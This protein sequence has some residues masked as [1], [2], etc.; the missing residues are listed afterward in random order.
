MKQSFYVWLD[1]WIFGSWQPNG[2]WLAMVRM[3]FASYFLFYAGNRLDWM[4]HFPHAFFDPPPSLAMLFPDFP[5]EW[6]FQVLNVLQVI[7]L[8]GILFG[9]YTR[10]NSVVFG[11]VMLVATSFMHSFGKINHISLAVFFPF[12][13]AWAGW[14]AEW[15]LDRFWR[16]K[17]AILSPVALTFLA[18]LAGFMFFT[19]G[20]V[21]ASTGWLDLGTQAVHSKIFSCYYVLGRTDL[22]ADFFLNLHIPWLWEIADW[23]VVIFEIAFLPAIFFP[24]IFRICLSVAVGFHLLVLLAMNIDFSIHFCVY[25]VFVDV[26]FL[27]KWTGKWGKAVGDWFSR[28]YARFHP[29]FLVFIAG[30]LLWVLFAHGSLFRWAIGGEEIEKHYAAGLVLWGMGF[31]Y[32]VA[33]VMVSI[34]RKSL[35]GH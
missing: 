19:A 3:L 26:D 24:K 27:R 30:G 34:F 16:K 15:S 31:V 6:F 13:M 2:K 35:R 8:V 20:W 17:K 33:S 4:A 25:A 29:M 11:L 1:G 12:I 22:L 18:T 28:F 23:V 14:G 10:L 21:K 7:S 32:V 5:A 9:Y